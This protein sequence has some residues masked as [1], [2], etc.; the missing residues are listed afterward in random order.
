MTADTPAG[1][2]RHIPNALT[3]LRLVLAA[4]VF[5]LLARFQ[6]TGLGAGSAHTPDATSLQSPHASAQR[7]ILLAAAI[8]FILAATTDFLDGYLA[9]KWRVVSKFGRVMDPFADKI[10]ILG[11]FILLAGPNFAISNPDVAGSGDAVALTG[12][13]PWMVVVILA[14]EL[15]VTSLRA[16][17][18]GSGVDFSAT[19]SGKLK[20]VLQSVAVPVILL[21]VAYLPHWFESASGAIVA[22]TP[23]PAAIAAWLT[24][25]VTAWSGLPYVVRAIRAGRTTDRSLPN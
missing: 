21:S 25:L 14:R 2:R 12:V 3:I 23:L 18:E 7:A 9:R 20:M 11:S 6:A 4:V 16:A 19:L 17:L 5:V 10:L 22:R 24:T 15:L 1:S 8:L 13:Q